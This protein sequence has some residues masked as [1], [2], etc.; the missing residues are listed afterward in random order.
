MNDKL[1]EQSARSTHMAQHFVWKRT[2]TAHKTYI[3]YL[4]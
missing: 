4:H 1:E 3:I 2:V